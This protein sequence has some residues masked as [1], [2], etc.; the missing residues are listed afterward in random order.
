MVWELRRSIYLL[1]RAGLIQR[2]ADVTVRG[3]LTLLT[4]WPT[5][6]VAVEPSTRVAL[7]QMQSIYPMLA[8]TPLTIVLQDAATVAD[9]PAEKLEQIL[10][11][12]SVANLCLYRPWEKGYQITRLA[13]PMAHVPAIGVDII[14]AQEAKL[15]QMRQFIAGLACRWQMIRNHFGEELASRVGVVIAAIPSSAIHGVA[16]PAA[17]RC[18]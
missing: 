3:N 9:I 4:D 7:E 1:E 14:T 5:L 18:A 17:R 15:A 8:W 10:I 13:A 16:R 12:L 2:G 6:L 11:A